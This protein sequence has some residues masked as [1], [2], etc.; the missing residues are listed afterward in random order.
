ME[1]KMTTTSLSETRECIRG[2]D[3]MTDANGGI[4]YRCNKKG[5]NIV[6]FTYFDFIIL[7]CRFLFFY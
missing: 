6:L 2:L 5:E 1:R 7:F 4:L 3:L